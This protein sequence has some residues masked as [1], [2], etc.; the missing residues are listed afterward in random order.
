MQDL[1]VSIIQSNLFW[2]DRE[3]NLLAF[4]EKIS[5]IG[6]QTDL[7]LLPEMFTTGF[8]MNASSLAEKMDGPS[9]H[10]MKKI[11]QEQNCTIAGSLI[12]E[13]KGNYYNRLI[14]MT[15]DSYE[16]YDKRHLFSL[17]GEEKTYK[18]GIKKI[19]IHLKGWRILPLICY[20]LR[21]PVWSR[22]SK[23][24]DYDLLL[25]VANWPERRIYAWKQLLI[26][27][28]IENQSYT[29][30]LNR[31]GNDGNQIFHSGDSAVIDFMG[32]NMD[33]GKNSGEFSKAYALSKEPQDFF[34]K[35]FAFFS[36]SD[37]FEIKV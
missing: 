36:D 14:W 23:I 6:E 26:A 35:Q 29:I 24:S 17:A 33:K 21:F 34:R 12:I 19:I 4:S 18:A 9:I 31:Y 16:Y 27:R 5:A 32:E 8:S 7:I 11:A 25:Y 22:R 10:W 20:D 30:G 2:E 37:N 1:K 28:A 3:K 15:P 13:E